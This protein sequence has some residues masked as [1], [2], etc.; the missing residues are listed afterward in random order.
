MF[1]FSADLIN[2]ILI[3]CWVFVK[4][5]AYS[6]SA[7]KGWDLK[8][9]NF[10]YKKNEKKNW[11]C[12]YP[13]LAICLNYATYKLFVVST[14]CFSLGDATLTD[15]LAPRN[16][17]FVSSYKRILAI[18]QQL[19]KTF[20]I[21]NFFKFKYIKNVCNQRKKNH[22]QNQDRWPLG[23]ILSVRVAFSFF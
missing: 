17:R 11:E 2:M 12:G 15:I 13:K 9:G 6:H 8:H 18:K 19:L 16:Y 22:Y 14:H 21:Y 1:G 3:W 5:L 7:L 10:F 23:A 4:R 20:I